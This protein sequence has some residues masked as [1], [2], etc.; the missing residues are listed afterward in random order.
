[1]P[2]HSLTVVLGVLLLAARP[3]YAGAAGIGAAEQILGEE[4]RTWAASGD[5]RAFMVEHGFARFATDGSE[6]ILRAPPA[7]LGQA[8]RDWRPLGQADRAGGEER[9]SGVEV[10]RLASGDRRA[11]LVAMLRGGQAEAAAEAAF[12][13]FRAETTA[14]A[15]TSVGLPAGFPPEVGVGYASG[16]SVG[17][18]YANTVL[19]AS[20]DGGASHAT[21]DDLWALVHS[22]V[23]TM[24]ATPKAWGPG[25]APLTVHLSPERQADGT[26]EF[27]I[28]TQ[29]TIR[30]YWLR[31]T[32]HGGVLQATA[33]AIYVI[34]QVGQVPQLEIV[35]VSPDLAIGHRVRLR[36]REAGGE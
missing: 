33:E 10:C 12:Y 23:T 1:M 16:L 36:L 32:A 35:A 8:A 24:K 21:Q 7:A 22:I 5:G 15:P 27:T 4:V 9:A 28:E 34:P 14:S 13:G 29:P 25:R 18:A 6:L 20:N 2:R 31:A 3:T 19:L 17:V 30:D 11:Q 26:R